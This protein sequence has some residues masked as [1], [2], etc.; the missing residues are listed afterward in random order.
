MEIDY[1]TIISYWRLTIKA[2]KVV[3]VILLSAAAAV[4]LRQHEIQSQA[5]RIGHRGP[6]PK[7]LM[8]MAFEECLGSESLLFHSFAACDGMQ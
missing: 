7:S 1:S 4:S 3:Y 8:K 2:W 6:V 5:E